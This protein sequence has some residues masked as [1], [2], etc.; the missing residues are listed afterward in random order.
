M[1]T[2]R[3]LFEQVH[4]LFHAHG[5]DAL[6]RSKDA[7]RT[8]GLNINSDFYY[9]E[10]YRD[11][12]SKNGLIY[13]VSLH[14][15]TTRGT[16]LF[17]LLNNPAWYRSFCDELANNIAYKEELTEEFIKKVEA[18]LPKKVENFNCHS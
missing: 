8:L 9:M 2:S 7:F 3:L 12:T 18:I 10:E 6:N 13:A 4:G 1:I 17:C 15:A 14:K 16:T 11:E 5:F